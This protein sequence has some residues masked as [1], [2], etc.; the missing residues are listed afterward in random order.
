MTQRPLIIEQPEDRFALIDTPWGQL[1]AWKASAMAMGA[2]G[3]LQEL[4]NVYLTVRN[5]ASEASARADEA[6]AQRTLIQH[7]CDQIAEFEKR[8]DAHVARLAEAEDKRRADERAEQ[9]A[10]EFEEEPLTLPPDLAARQTS[11]PPTKIGDETTPPG[12][13]LHAVPAKEEPE[14]DLEVEDNEGDLPPEIA[15]LPDPPPE[16]KGKVYPPPT[17]L[18]GS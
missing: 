5:D 6:Q 16:S 4:H 12:G 17:A 3:A 9:A 2:A 8:F 14:P 1:P 15:P 13:E 7:V 18:F 11:A 10:R